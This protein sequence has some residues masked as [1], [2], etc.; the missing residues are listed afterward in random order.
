MDGPSNAGRRA[1]RRRVTDYHE[2]CLAGLLAH[3]A[4]ALGGY[5]AGRLSV[6]EADTA[7]HQ[8]DRAA[9]EL[10]TFCNAVGSVE[11]VARTID[12]MAEPVDWWDRGEPRRPTR[13]ERV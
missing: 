11:L 13:P 9:Q 2:A 12:A 1:A 5:R 7:I 6:A 8:Y 4:A 3:V 10:W